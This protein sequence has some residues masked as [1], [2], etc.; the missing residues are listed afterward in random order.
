[1]E[2][3]FPHIT[4]FKKLMESLETDEIGDAMVY[5]EEAESWKD[6]CEEARA[7]AIFLGVA[8]ADIVEDRTENHYSLGGTKQYIV[9]DEQKAEEMAQES[10]KETI[11]ECVLSRIPEDLRFYFDTD[12]FFRDNSPA[13]NAEQLATYDGHENT[14]DLGDTTYYIYRTN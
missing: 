7:L 6:L 9:A 3:N 8:P 5:Q 11:E 10:Y 1:M 12:A 4:E 14:Q 2:N 13:E